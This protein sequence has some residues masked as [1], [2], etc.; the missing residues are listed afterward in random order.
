MSLVT[1]KIENELVEFWYPIVNGNINHVIAPF[2][3]DLNKVEIHF[4]RELISGK[5]DSWFR[6]E[7]VCRRR[8]GR[9]YNSTFF[10]RDGGQAL[11][12]A[13]SRLKRELVRH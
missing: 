4:L 1:F 3:S 6:C 7:I 12:D 2:R 10:N 11:T 8:G 9:T 5:K 13:L